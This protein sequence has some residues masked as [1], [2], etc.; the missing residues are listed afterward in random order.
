MIDMLRRSPSRLAAAAWLLV[1]AGT[2]AAVQAPPEEVPIGSFQ[3]QVSVSWALV[4][5]LVQSADGY[6]DDLTRDDFRLW[7]DDLEVPIA[8]FESGATAPVSLVFLQDLSGSMANGGK[9]VESRRA[10]AY[11]LSKAR[12]ED[13]FALAT[14]A[15]DLLQVEVPFTREEQVLAEAMDLWEGYGTT[16][17]HDAVAWIPSIG[18]EGRHPKRAVVL[19]SDG[20]DNASTV[21]PETARQVV[22][23][24]QLPVYVLG[25]GR[26]DPAPDGD[27]GATYARLLTDLALATGGSY[28]Q[29]APG[30]EVFRAAA[31]L[32]EQLRRQYVLAF[33]TRAGDAGYRRIRVEVTANDRFTVYHRRGYRGGPPAAGP[34]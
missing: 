6:V 9:L 15:G 27:G 34:S 17:L 29:V 22:R 4:P 3:E 30:E 19:V 11:L 16:A 32:L 8:D 20:V 5:V 31:N 18:A 33:P 25:L 1:L 14:F 24:A 26:H 7:V 10:L 28:Y 2:A 13:E 12:P 21:T 23:D